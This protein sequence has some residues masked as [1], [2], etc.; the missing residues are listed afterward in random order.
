MLLQSHQLDQKLWKQPLAGGLPSVERLSCGL[1]APWSPAAEIN[2]SKVCSDS[3]RVFS[4]IL[5]VSV[6]AAARLTSNVKRQG[7][8]ERDFTATRNNLKI[9]P[10]RTGLYLGRGSSPTEGGLDLA[11]LL[12]TLASRPGLQAPQST[13]DATA[14]EQSSNCRAHAALYKGYSHECQNLNE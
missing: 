9:T 5:S 2:C 13:A 3:R 8:C 7:R 11:D 10:S 14:I 12:A 1:A 6:Q 4:T